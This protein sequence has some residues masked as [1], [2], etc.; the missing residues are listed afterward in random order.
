MPK[1]QTDL[2]L[3]HIY[4]LRFNDHFHASRAPVNTSKTLYPVEME[5]IGRLIAITPTQYNLEQDRQI[6]DGETCMHSV[7]GVMKPCV[8]KITDL[9]KGC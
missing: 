9:G 7:F 2:K 5:V 4:L 6:D 1:K 8:T 3:G